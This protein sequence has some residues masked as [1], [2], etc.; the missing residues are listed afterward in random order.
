[1]DG[2]KVIASPMST[3]KDGQKVTMVASA[4]NSSVTQ[5]AAIKSVVAAEPAAGK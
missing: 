3:L 1:V 5:A 2:D 4:G